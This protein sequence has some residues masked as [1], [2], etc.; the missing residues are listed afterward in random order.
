MTIKYKIQ[1]RS[2]SFNSVLNIN[3]E[4]VDEL[5]A[6][7]I[8]SSI[9][10]YI[11]SIVDGDDVPS[12]I[13]PNKVLEILNQDAIKQSAESY[14]L[15]MIGDLQLAVEKRMRTVDCNMHVNSLHYDENGKLSDVDVT[16]KFSES[17]DK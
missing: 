4:L 13:T 14:L 2:H 6:A 15:D 10:S 17:R 7:A 9:E 3:K 11:D 8:L 12:S 1:S 16:P 5:V